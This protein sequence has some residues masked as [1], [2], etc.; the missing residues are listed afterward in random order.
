MSEALKKHLAGLGTLP[1]TNIDAVAAELATKLEPLKSPALFMG[2]TVDVHPAAFDA[3][4]ADL[5]TRHKGLGARVKQAV[6]FEHPEIVKQVGLAKVA[7]DL[8]PI[9]AAAATDA[10][11]AKRQLAAL[12]A[13]YDVAHAGLG[14]KLIKAVGEHHPAVATSMGLTHVP[15]VTPPAAAPKGKAPKPGSLIVETPASRRAMERAAVEGTTAEVGF[16]F[17]TSSATGKS[18]DK[19]WSAVQ[20]KH[21]RLGELTK[22]LEGD[23]GAKL[24][25]AV[26]ATKQ[27]DVEALTKS[28]KSSGTDFERL[29]ARRY[30]ALE[31]KKA[32]LAVSFD[33]EYK[34]A[35][36]KA[37]KAAVTEAY[38]ESLKVIQKEQEQLAKMREVAKTKAGHANFIGGSASGVAKGTEEAIAAAGGAKGA[39]GAV[40]KVTGGIPNKAAEELGVI[41]KKALD[42]KTFLGRLR[43]NAYANI[44]VASIDKAGK[45]EASGLGGKS[46]KIGGAFLG[47]MIGAQGLYDFGKVVGLVRSTDEQGKEVPADSAT[48]LKAGA[49]G[50]LAIAALYATVAKK[51]K[52]AG[53]ST[54]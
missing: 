49:E 12:A 52:A 5:E 3:L 53:I 20:G 10:P 18:L 9:I 16:G 6:L 41:G 14:D 44:N 25:D 36:G 45:V 26:R 19:H 33:E 35:S 7:P 51:G 30:G 40:A 31:T 13:Q 2:R 8:A 46:M 32:K 48:A 27:A 50:L 43:A 28:L 39:A 21:E 24:S 11:L 34:A 37:G 38:E 42:N 47:T 29:A 17:D 54:M 4:V 15:V 1:A 22:E 23:A